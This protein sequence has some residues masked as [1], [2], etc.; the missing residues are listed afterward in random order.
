M[1]STQEYDIEEILREW[2]RW[3]LIDI[4]PDGAGYYE[5][6][7]TGAPIDDWEIE[8]MIY[9]FE[10]VAGVRYDGYSQNGTK[11]VIYISTNR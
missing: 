11:H 6:H 4:K 8:E 9:L 2:A 10:D 5:V 7:A 1:N 3:T